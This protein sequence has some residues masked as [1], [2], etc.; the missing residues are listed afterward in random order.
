MFEIITVLAGLAAAVGLLVFYPVYF[1]G[2][3]RSLWKLLVPTDRMKRIIRVAG[4]VIFAGLVVLVLI[5]TVSTVSTG[6]LTGWTWWHLLIIP[7]V[8]VVSEF[9]DW[10]DRRALRLNPNQE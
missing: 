9:E 10:A 7:I 5:P 6:V 2:I 1:W 8:I 4:C 3:V